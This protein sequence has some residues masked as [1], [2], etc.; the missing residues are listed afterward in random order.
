MKKYILTGGPG[1]GKSSILLAL[2]QRGEHIV[3]EAA[4]DYIKVR[5]AQGQPEPW[6]EPDFQD[7]ILELQLQREEQIPEGIERIFIDRGVADG[8][9]YAEPGTKIY[10]KIMAEARKA[11]WI[12]KD[13]REYMFWVRIQGDYSRYYALSNKVFFIEQLDFTEKTK[14][15]RENHKEA[16]RLGEKLKAIY[17][18][19]GYKII[20][21][22]AAKL[23]ERVRR[24]LQGVE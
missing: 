16:V 23:E 21:V 4:E 18:R 17:H 3:K 2:E 6:T 20:G 12:D 5:Q 13:Q 22:P 11:S 7:K 8:L 10:K 9:A 14:V 1:T 15:R 19:L 24:V